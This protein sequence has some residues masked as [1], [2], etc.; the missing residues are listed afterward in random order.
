MFRKFAKSAS[1]MLP[2][3]SLARE[4][5]PASCFDET[6]AVRCLQVFLSPECIA[7][8]QTRFIVDQ[9]QRHTTSSCFNL[10]RTMQEQALV[11]IVRAAG[12]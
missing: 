1:E 12:I 3:P 11:E 4:V 6:L 5:A 8:I 9:M 2:D 10:A 7:L